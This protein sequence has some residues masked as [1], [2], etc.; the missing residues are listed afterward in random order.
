MA[1]ESAGGMEAA[2][3]AFV[4]VSGD[5]LQVGG[6]VEIDGNDEDLTRQTT[7]DLAVDGGFFVADSISVGGELGYL[8]TSSDDDGSDFV[9][10]TMTLLAVG[11]YHAPVSSSWALLAQLRAGYFGLR[12]E[13]DALDVVTTASGFAFGLGGG[14][15]FL[16]FSG[17][18]NGFFRV[19]CTY[20]RFTGDF[21]IDTDI[22]DADGDVQGYLLRLRLGLGIAF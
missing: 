22:G 9:Q 6:E 3:T 21:E 4:A 13:Q 18:A 1:Q 2:G 10:R 12:A 15:E 14:A 7:L 16:L 11:G 17:S 5:V 20:D 8:R 19:L